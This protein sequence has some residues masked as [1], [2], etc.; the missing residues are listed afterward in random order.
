MSPSTQVDAVLANFRAL[1]GDMDMVMYVYV[2]DAQDH[3]QGVVGFRELLTANPLQT[4]GEI[5]A[6]NIRS[7]SPDETLSDALDRFDRYDFRAIPIVNAE[8]KLISVV[9]FRDIRGIK[10]RLH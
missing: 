5:M 8:N 10:S 1:A 9:S 4:L 2:I 7:L 3:L 6:C